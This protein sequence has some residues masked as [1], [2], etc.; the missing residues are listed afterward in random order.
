[1]SSK[2]KLSIGRSLRNGSHRSPFQ[3][4][5]LLQGFEQLELRRLMA[6]DLNW[7]TRPIVGEYT[8]NEILVQYLPGANAT[9]RGIARAATSGSV[10]EQIFTKTMQAAGLGRM[11]RITLGNGVA[12]PQAI[13]ALANNPFVAYAE[14]NYIYKPALVSND[15]YY[16]NGSLWGMYGDD[17]PSAVGPAGTTN[18]F[19]SQAEKAW[20]DNIV[21]K[22]S[23]VVGII[24]EGVQ[25]T[26]PDLVNNIWVNPYETPN[27]GIDNDG[28][29]Y[30]DDTNGWDFVNNDK[31]VYDAGGDSHG[32]HVAGT[33]GGDG[34]NGAGVVGVNWDV[35]M[36]STKFLGTNGGSTANAVKALDYLTDLKS[37]H[38]INIVATNNSWGGGGYSQSLHDAIIRSAKS[39][40]LFVAAAGNSTTNNDTTASYPSNYRTT[41]GTTTQTA[42]AYD[43]VIAVA[44]ISNTGAIASFSSYGATT[45]DIGAP[46][47]S[48]NS[49]VPTNTYASYNGTSMATPHVT[50]AVA[51]FASVQPAGV[52]ASSIKTAILSSAVPTASLA[53]KT[54]T[55]GRLNAYAAL[56]QA[57]SIALDKSV[58]GAPSTASV[59]VNYSA[60]NLNA[61]VADTI[62]ITVQ[63]SSELTS[64]A[65]T[66]T[67]TGINTGVF[68]GSFGLL[69]ASSAGD[70]NLAV[71]NGDTITATCTAI[72]KS[73]SATVDLIA[74][75][76]S[77]VS[78]MPQ[79][80]TSKIDWNTNESSTTVVLY[81]TN[82]SNLDK[83]SI[84]TTLSTA[85][86][87]T[88]IGLLPGTTYYYQV[89]SAD[90]AGNTSTSS[91]LSFATLA[92]AA[93]L[94]VD[95]DLGAAY[96]VYFTNAL[97]A[98]S[99]DFD[100]W[101]SLAVGNTPSSTQL[102]SY[103]TVIWNTGY[104]YSTSTA[105]LAAGL[106]PSEQSQIAGYLN[107]GGR[108][109]ISGQDILY[110]FGS[111]VNSATFRQNYLKVTAFTNDA[112]TA[113]H[114]ETGVAGNAITNGMSLAIAKP[115]DYPSLYIDALSPAAGATGLLT[116]GL[117]TT[118]N[119][120][121]AV[122]YRGDYSVGGFGMVFLSVPFE[123]ISTTAASPNNQTVFLKRTLDFLAGTAGVD[124]SAP[125]A[126][127]T[128]EAGGTVTVQV[129]LLVPPTADVM[130]PVASSNLAEGTVN[131]DS[132]T[133]TPSNWNVPQTVT[134][135]G[136]NDDIDDGNI[137]YN[138]LFG[139]A[140]STDTRY[141]GF[142]PSDTTLTNTDNDTA[143][144]TVS[145]LSGSTTSETGA[146]VT[147]TIMLNSQP[148]ASVTVPLT[149]SDATEGTVSQSQVVFTAANWNQ[150]ITI[151]VTGVD[152]TILDGNIA[153]TAAIAV[154]TS[155]DLLYNGINPADFSITNLDDEVE[156]PTKFFVVDDGTTDRNYH[157]DSNGGAIKNYTIN[158]ANTAPRGIATTSAGTTL[159]VVDKNK[160][161]YV[162]TNTG[163]LLGSWTAGSLASNAT[164][165]GIA[166][167]GT[168]I[169]LVDS[170][171]DRVYY[172]ANAAALTSGTATATSFVLATGNTNPKDVVFGV[173]NN[174]RYLWVVND[175]TTDT[176]YRY[177]LGTNGLV[178]GS[179]T[180]W[181][182]N[183]ANSRPTG[184]TVDPSNATQ[185]LWVVD[186]GTDRVYKYANG[187][188]GAAAL[189]SS[190]AL[191]TGNTN[192]QGIADPP[193]AWAAGWVDE[194]ASPAAHRSVSAPLPDQPS[195]ASSRSRIVVSVQ[196][197]ATST[198][199]VF[200]RDIQRAFDSTM[201]SRH[202]R[203]TSAL[204]AIS[205]R[206]ERWSGAPTEISSK[207]PGLRSQR[208]RAHLADLAIADL[209]KT[210]GFET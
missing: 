51:L 208:D 55:G 17:T 7:S 56:Q 98:N 30:I 78:A 143:G 155:T 107:G 117:T 175:A 46:G 191:A 8:P 50:G 129:S 165:E 74:P 102:S 73:T 33:I 44:A 152:D 20:N 110:N 199:T 136:V 97:A 112:I 60:A 38:G 108:M 182:L 198:E 209:L 180:S 189:T 4:R 151:T 2:R 47:V 150:P 76:L 153:Y 31:T 135:T 177:A 18:T 77:S 179:A 28:N 125:S 70:G 186:S 54:L 119:P 75:T 53:G 14:P 105:T 162:Y 26:H 195:D 170:R 190:F 85:H 69:T 184:I 207:S 11:E 72:S 188:T 126:P 183:S 63:S 185:D 134:V 19:G 57:S 163:T 109:L 36:I 91:V 118:T 81:G 68:S 22:S 157:Y 144:I 137:G 167:D 39:N 210:G 197:G 132:V 203:T 12:V 174:I 96:D 166:T 92:P 169:W 65:I 29:G 120:F 103:Q 106:S 141:N 142:D 131:V 80:L 114:T 172:Y 1:M 6:A 140:S 173:T 139:A 67:E 138:I 124:V 71:S 133:F 88:L 5:K 45:V 32:T 156:P 42:A 196:G 94:F 147:F 181:R 59:T 93:I 10:S 113:N 176:V 100:V 35:T 58:Y 104:D 40:I 3:F 89:Q 200:N 205:S 192:P 15:T 41:V 16:T 164:V 194:T 84:N 204:F 23:V 87:A 122:S 25:V 83:S 34:G 193:P 201:S 146:S 86:S 148:T 9:Q 37:R 111:D 43:S 202:P 116:H 158:S 115:A 149:S 62:Q 159:W 101:D 21:G 48:I 79:R 187:R 52:S 161:V 123:S 206:G 61:S 171:A 178:A 127:A 145:A 128:T 90:A 66:L 13:V 49:S 130:I 27:D 160:K 24:D 121:T 95:D 82:A 154:A 99:L 168:N 64:E